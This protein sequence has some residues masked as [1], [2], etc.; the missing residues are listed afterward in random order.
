MG[1]TDGANAATAEEFIRFLVSEGWLMHY[2]EFSGE[3]VLPPISK[4]R[5][6]LFWLDPSDPHR[7][8]AAMQVTSRPPLHNDAVASGNWRH[9]LVEQKGI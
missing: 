7:M 4:L 2:L 5:D 8:A 3:R 6:Q 1:F 9:E